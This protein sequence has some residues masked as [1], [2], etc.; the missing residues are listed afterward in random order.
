LKKKTVLL[1]LFLFSSLLLLNLNKNFETVNIN[2]NGLAS[3]SLEIEKLWEV[4]E[5][6]TAIYIGEGFL[7]SVVRTFNSI[8]TETNITE[9]KSAVVI[10]KRDIEDGSLVWSKTVELVNVT[11]WLSHDSVLMKEGFLY[12]VWRYRNT[13]SLDFSLLSK[14]TAEGELVWNLTFD[15]VTNPT[16]SEDNES[17][18]VFGKT[19][20]PPSPYIARIF[21]NGVI[22]WNRTI[23]IE[24]DDGLDDFSS[25]GIWANEE[26]V[27]ALG[28]YYSVD[29]PFLFKISKEGEFI[30]YK[31]LRGAGK[32]WPSICGN[33]ESLFI[34]SNNYGSIPREFSISKWN[35]DGENIWTVLQNDLRIGSI[36]ANNKNL[37]SSGYVRMGSLFQYEFS[38]IE[39]DLEGNAHWDKREANT[40]IPST[41]YFLVKGDNESLYTV[42]PWSIIR[43]KLPQDNGSPNVNPQDYAIIILFGVASASVI[44]IAVLIYLKAR[45]KKKMKMIYWV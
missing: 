15:G 10:S 18:Y 34:A 6:A 35:F 41:S 25:S 45:R 33:S 26:N 3:A 8:L 27:Y 4:N 1:A 12:T 36:W 24:F 20:Y 21:N 13:T 11:I 23:E 28:S 32:G 40:G 43:W 37:Y 7:Y 39:L 29:W 22:D 2:S 5:T 30:W 9:T 38:L 16:L 19:G 44:G 14:W 17:V 31:E 42:S